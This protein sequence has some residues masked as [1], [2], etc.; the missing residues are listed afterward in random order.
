MVFDITKYGAIPDGKTICTK[1]IQHAIDDCSKQGGQV[2][3]PEGCF[4]SGSLK[5][6]SN[7][8]LHLEL[9]ARLMC[10]TNPADQ[11][12]FLKDMDDDNKDTGW[13]GGCFLFALH[14]ENVMISGDGIIDG[15]GRFYYY[16][17]EEEDYKREI[18]HALHEPR[19]RMS[20]L[21]DIHNLTVRDVTLEDAAFWTLHLAGCRDVLIENIRIINNERCPNNDGIDPDSCQNVIIHNCDIQTA[22]DCIVIKSTAPMARLY[23]GSSNIVVSGCI[24][25]SHCTALKIGTETWGDISKIIVSD[26]ILR[27]C[28]RGFGIFSRDGGKISDILVHHLTGNTR[29]FLDCTKENPGLPAWWGTGDPFYISATKRNGVERLPGIIEDIYLD[30]IYLECEGT[31]FVGGEKYA[32]IC[33]VAVT[34]SIFNYKRQ[35]KC[36]AK[37]IDERPS[38][39]NYFS[40]YNSCL[41]LRCVNQ[42][43]I[44]ESVFRID[45]TMK[46]VIKTVIYSKTC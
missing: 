32:E 37:W 24:L 29:G 20:Y 44:S 40:N 36:I 42:V 26:C 28:N 6:R 17:K 45:E 7:T 16:D 5:L 2:L 46:N 31:A 19:P 33:N 1:A 12:N 18:P 25:K 15:Q 30:H 27:D 21:E 39:R 8:D 13:D 38:K 34:D 41:Y 10:S 11:I 4:V 43:N 22:D 23:G 9:G 14:E 3:I 35:T